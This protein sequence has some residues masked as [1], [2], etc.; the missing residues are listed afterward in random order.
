MRNLTAL[1]LLTLVL[2]LFAASSTRADSVPDADG[3][4]LWIYYTTN[5]QVDQNVENA[6]AL[7]RR[8]AKAG[9]RYILLSDSK[10]AHLANV[11]GTYAHNVTEV[12]KIAADLHMVIV[13]AVFDVGYSN[14]LLNNDPNLAEGLPV[15]DTP[16]VV[17]GGQ[18]T[19]DAEP[20]NLHKPTYHDDNL[21]LTGGTAT[22]QGGTGNS[23]MSFKLKLPRY[24]CYHVSVKI[25]T[26]GLRS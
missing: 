3:R 17:R 12:K 22:F 6:R 16:M 2:P 26:A 8:A 13:P 11:P 18:A 14:N 24:R 10:L 15:R 25:K 9:Y 1:C 19:V 21:E 20:L 23:R 4:D 5:L 7:W